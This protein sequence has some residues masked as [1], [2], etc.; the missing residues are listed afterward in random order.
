MGSP[1][2]KPFH[3][4]YP[5][6]REEQ[7]D[8]ELRNPKGLFTSFLLLRPAHFLRRRISDRGVLR[9]DAGPPAADIPVNMNQH[10]AALNHFLFFAQLLDII[11]DDDGKSAEPPHLPVLEGSVVESVTNRS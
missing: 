1:I 3:C 9:T 11:P 6:H 8:E 5:D 10:P 4:D 2:V 7:H